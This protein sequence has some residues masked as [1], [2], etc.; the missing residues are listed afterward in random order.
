MC[1]DGYRDRSG[2]LIKILMRRMKR[3]ILTMGS[4]FIFEEG[5]IS[6]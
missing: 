6:C 5:E 1:V 2:R 3:K 4:L